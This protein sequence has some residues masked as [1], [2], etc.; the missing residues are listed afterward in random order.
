MSSSGWS[1]VGLLNTQVSNRR[2]LILFS[3]AK[4]G[5]RKELH[6]EEQANTNLNLDN[7]TTAEPLNGADDPNRIRT[8]RG[9]VAQQ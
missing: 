4:I 9:F 3:R 8:E 7:T 5:Y 2:S 1:L 6:L